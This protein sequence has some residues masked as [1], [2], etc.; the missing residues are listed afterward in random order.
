ML[1]NRPESGFL[2]APVETNFEQLDADVAILG[3]PYGWPY[4]RPGSTAPK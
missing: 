1:T 2:G 4:P 3:V